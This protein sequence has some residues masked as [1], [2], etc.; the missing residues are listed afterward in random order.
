MSDS[1]IHFVIS[2]PRSGST[3][4]CQ[5]L[6]EHPDVFATEQRLFGKFGEIWKNN[7]GSTSPRI[8]FDEFAE[9]FAGHYF[10]DEMGL[11]RADFLRRFQKGFVN[12]L[13]S[14][15]QRQSG[16][17][18]VVDKITP[19]HG[20]GD[21]V[22]RQ[23]GELFPDS[24]IV[25]LVRDGRDVVTSGVFDWIQ[26]EG[27]G[28]LRYDFFIGPRSGV[29][30]ERFFDDEVLAQ[31]ADHWRESIAMFDGV[32]DAF[33]LRYESMKSDHA[34]ELQRLFEF[35]N[36]NSALE[37]VQQCA[38][39]TTF[40][41]R[42]GRR[43]GTME[44]AAKARKGV[45]GDWQNWFTRKDGQVFHEIAGAELVGLGYVSDDG[46]WKELPERLVGVSDS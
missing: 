41:S 44:A 14:F 36:V 10:H 11:D 28:A 15:A 21:I 23:I 17:S 29:R 18:I 19:Y 27:A 38:K 30:L 5:A 9:S 45:V 13:V 3:W 39:S 33:Q 31:W 43:P 22:M 40:E 4:L 32:P 8:T 2:A 1:K 16:K 25:Q 7:D 34:G 12:F 35:L 46:W 6:N 20:T 37:V 26:R 24:K 42:T